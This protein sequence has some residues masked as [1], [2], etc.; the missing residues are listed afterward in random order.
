MNNPSV[1]LEEEQIVC[2]VVCC[3]IWAD[4]SSTDMLPG[5]VSLSFVLSKQFVS[6]RSKS[7]AR[8]SVVRSGQANLPPTCCPVLSVYSF[9]LSKQFVSQRSKSF[10][11]LSVVRSG[12]TNLPPTCCP[13]LSVYLSFFPNSLCRRGANRLHGCLL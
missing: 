4:K 5:F 2:T 11:R 13:V 3:E 10:A 9:V 7:F 8:L 12:Q 1:I 6:Q